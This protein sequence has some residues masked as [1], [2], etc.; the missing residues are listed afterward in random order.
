MMKI[1]DAAKEQI[2]KVTG[3]NPGKVMRVGVA[4]FG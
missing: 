4:G 2:K 1:S 3:K